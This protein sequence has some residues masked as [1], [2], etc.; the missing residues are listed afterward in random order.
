MVPQA[1]PVATVLAR[2]GAVWVV[3]AL[4]ETV[5]GVLRNRLLVP[6]VGQHRAGQIG[7]V[8]GSLIILVVAWLSIRWIGA[9]RKAH[10]LGVGGLW[11]VLMLAFEVG[12]GRA[13]GISW[14]RIVSAYDLTEGGLMLI[15]MGVLFLAPLLAARLRQVGWRSR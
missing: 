9:G 4:A 11:L 8:V 5:H 10:L 2:G 7:V 1:T 3:I 13:L 15:G 14:D 6:V 12:L